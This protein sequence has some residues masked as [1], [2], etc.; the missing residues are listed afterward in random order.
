MNA[1]ARNTIEPPSR[2]AQTRAYELLRVPLASAAFDSLRKP[3]TLKQV[4]LRLEAIR[5]RTRLPPHQA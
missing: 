2:D 4:L 1:N 5:K 3:R